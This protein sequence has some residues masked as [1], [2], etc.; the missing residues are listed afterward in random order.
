FLAA[1]T[2]REGKPA[3]PAVLEIEL[4]LD[5]V[6][7]GRR[8]RILEIRHVDI[9]AG[10]EGVDDHLAID[11]PRDLDAAI[12]EILGDRRTLPVAF[13]DMAGLVQEVRQLAGIE[14]RL[15]RRAASQKP[16]A[17]GIEP[18]VQLGQEP[19]RLWSQDLVV[20]RP[21]PARDRHARNDAEAWARAPQPCCAL[22]RITP[23]GGVPSQ[24]ADIHA[25]RAAPLGQAA[26][27]DALGGFARRNQRS[28]LR[29]ELAAT[30]ALATG[31]DRLACRYGFG[32]LG[33]SR[34][35]PSWS[36]RSSGHGW[37]PRRALYRASRTGDSYPGSNQARMTEFPRTAMV[38]PA[39]AGSNQAPARDSPAVACSAPGL[40]PVAA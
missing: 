25:R 36:R 38:K 24:S 9:G 20:A 10:I 13:T 2:I 26:R 30:R 15:P 11:R 32:G 18:A 22:S 5:V 6:R 12:D 3:R 40:A 23:G 34:L 29:C 16:L 33:L 19:E 31:L 21:G 1:G 27:G 17:R 4:A 8:V 14:A 7:P 28:R 37:S 39:A 35:I